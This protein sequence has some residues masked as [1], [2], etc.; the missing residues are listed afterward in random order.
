MPTIPVANRPGLDL[1]R[2]ASRSVPKSRLFL[3]FVVVITFF[4]PALIA[5]HG[6]KAG[7]VDA[8]AITSP[9]S[10]DAVI[11]APAPQPS[12]DQIMSFAYFIEQGDMTSTLR[13]NNNQLDPMTATVTFFNSHGESFTAPLL[14]LPPQDVQRFPIA[15]LTANAPDDFHAGSAQFSIRG[16]PWR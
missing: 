13:L 7:R 14:T 5:L 2:L 8:S 16:H 9:A 6:L 12:D 10:S 4:V 15:E 1:L 11:Q 3:L